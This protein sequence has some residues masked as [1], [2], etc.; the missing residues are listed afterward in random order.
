MCEVRVLPVSEFCHFPVDLI[1][2]LNSIRELFSGIAKKERVPL[3]L[4]CGHSSCENCILMYC[5]MN[6][7]IVCDVCKKESP[8]PA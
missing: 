3:I 5:Y 2:T 1:Q 6:R 7:P 8:L 4:G